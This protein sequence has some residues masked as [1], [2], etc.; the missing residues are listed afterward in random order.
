MFIEK[1]NNRKIK[2]F[3]ENFG[4]RVLEIHRNDEKIFILGRSKTLELEPSI[5]LED[6]VAYMSAHFARN[7]YILTKEWRKFLYSTFGN[8]Y[9]EKLKDNFE[10]RMKGYSKFVLS[11]LD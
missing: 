7:N 4:Y 5:W 1:I 9:K 3:I 2:K 6:Y 8:E 11:D 10:K